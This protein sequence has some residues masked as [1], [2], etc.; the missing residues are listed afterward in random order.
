ME[1]QAFQCVHF[2]NA[3]SVPV[4]LELKDLLLRLLEKNPNQRITIEEIRRHSWIVAGNDSSIPSTDENCCGLID[5][6]EE[7]IEGA[8]KKYQTPIHILVC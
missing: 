4:S 2:N 6:S 1:I 3:C 8:V 7:E 5:V